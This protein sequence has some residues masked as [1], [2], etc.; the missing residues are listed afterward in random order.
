MVDDTYERRGAEEPEW[1]YW[2]NRVEL[3]VM[4]GR[5]LIELGAPDKAQPLLS[6]A[7]ATYPAEHAREVALYLSWLA[8]SHVRA[9]DFDA[10]R[11]ALERG[12]SYSSAMPSA[13]T[14]NRLD[15]VQRLLSG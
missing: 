2:L 1:V 6:S 11:E 12:R 14:D 13:R 5:C 3:D 9:G 7:I 10:A 4:A 8:E 15:A